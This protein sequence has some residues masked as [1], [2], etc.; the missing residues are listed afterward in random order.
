MQTSP[1]SQR[2]FYV[3]TVPSIYVSPATCV[4]YVSTDT[5][6]VR[7]RSPCEYKRSFVIFSIFKVPAAMAISFLSYHALEMNHEIA[8]FAMSLGS[9]GTLLLSRLLILILHFRSFTSYVAGRQLASFA[10]L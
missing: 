5:N 3:Q 7:Y 10:D 1:K 8:S 9:R 4:C 6:S 2:L